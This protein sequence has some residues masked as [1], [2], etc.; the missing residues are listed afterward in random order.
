M[1][2]VQPPRHHAAPPERHGAEVG[3]AVEAGELAVR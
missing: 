2:D 1:P 3:L